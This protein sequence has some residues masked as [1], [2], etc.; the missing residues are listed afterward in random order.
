MAG[1]LEGFDALAFSLHGRRL[2]LDFTATLSARN[3]I[4][5]IERLRSPDDLARWLGAVGSACHG[6]ASESHLASARRLREGIRELADAVIAKRP[7]PF[8]ALEVVN[9][10]AGLPVATPQLTPAGTAVLRADDA[11]AAALSAIARDAVQVLGGRDRGRLK[12]CAA[13]DCA[14]LFV[15]DSRAGRRRWCSMEACGNRHKTRTYRRR[16]KG[17]LSDRAD[18]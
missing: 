1:V 14:L 2:C 16:R 12:E 7:L 8:M 4:A 9:H 15:D 6:G 11:V 18:R 5:P 13:P 3:G 10:W 17:P